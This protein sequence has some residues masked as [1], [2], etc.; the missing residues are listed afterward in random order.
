MKKMPLDKMISKELNSIAR[1]MCDK[2][3]K[4]GKQ[5]KED[6]EKYDDKNPTYFKHCTKC[7]MLDFH[8]AY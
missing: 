5:F 7:P 2:Y 6:Q 4:Y 1:E 8:N 3:C